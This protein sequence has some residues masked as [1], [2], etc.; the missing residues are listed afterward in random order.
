MVQDLLHVVKSE[1]SKD[2]ETT[3]Q[4]D[5]LRPHQGTG[6]G[7]G[8]DKGSKSGESNDSHTGKERSTQIQIL[9]LFSGGANESDRTHHANSV[10]TCAGEDSWVHEH[11]R[12]EESSLGDV[13]TSPESVLL[14]VAVNTIR[15]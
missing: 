9:L 5:I 14:D 15:R 12:C 3:I 8:K 7:G 4:P 11:Q 13:E 1:A 2:S 10:E 6:G